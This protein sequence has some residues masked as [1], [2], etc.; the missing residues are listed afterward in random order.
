L[1]KELWAH[2]LQIE[3]DHAL[4]CRVLSA[5]SEGQSGADIEQRAFAAR[6]RAALTSLPID[7]VAIAESMTLENHIISGTIHE[8]TNEVRRRIARELVSNH[9]ISQADVGRFLGISRQAVSSYLK[10]S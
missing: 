8:N 9:D 5:L 6:R 10:V 3:P 2:F 7:S 4:V 1:R